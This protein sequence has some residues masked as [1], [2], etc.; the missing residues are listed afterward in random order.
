MSESKVKIPREVAEAIEDL[1]EHF[2]I[3][4]SFY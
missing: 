3:K 2:T 1:G 4:G